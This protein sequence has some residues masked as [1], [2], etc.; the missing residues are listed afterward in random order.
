MSAEVVEVLRDLNMKLIAQELAFSVL[1][2]TLD[3]HLPGLADE[4]K[5]NILLTINKANPD[6]KGLIDAIYEIA[7]GI[8]S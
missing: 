3:E 8:G 7:E 5:N 4:T 1:V 6:N 2:A